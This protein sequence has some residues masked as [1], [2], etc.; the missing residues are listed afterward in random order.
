VSVNVESGKSAHRWRRRQHYAP[1]GRLLLA[2]L[3]TVLTMRA[4]LRIGDAIRPP[5]VSYS[6]VVLGLLAIRG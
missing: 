6:Q 3:R 4:T 5:P 2:S 1:T